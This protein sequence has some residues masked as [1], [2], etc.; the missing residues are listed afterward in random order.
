MRK[1]ILFKG[2]KIN[3][4]F[5]TI[6]KVKLLKI[7]LNLFKSK[8]YS[9]FNN[10]T[11][12]K[13]FFSDVANT[14]IIHF[15]VSIFWAT[16]HGLELLA[17]PVANLTADILFGKAMK[18]L[19]VNDKYLLFS[20]RPLNLCLL[21]QTCLFFF[22][23][24]LISIPYRAHS[25]H[26]IRFTLTI[27]NIEQGVVLRRSVISKN[28][29]LFLELLG[30]VTVIW[31]YLLRVHSIWVIMVDTFHLTTF[32]INFFWKHTYKN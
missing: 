6:K 3:P 28:T 10:D 25:A 7:S 16:V 12:Q 8:R 1:E 22:C 24:F 30:L 19:M 18:K 26:N 23:N 15:T 20:I 9:V 5:L 4:W 27:F 2:V 32:L 31:R 14:G 11:I 21:L 17:E 29:F 13:C